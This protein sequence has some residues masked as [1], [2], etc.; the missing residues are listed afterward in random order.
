M[1][2]DPS[3][4]DVTDDEYA[5]VA[6]LLPMPEARGRPRLQPW[7]EL[8]DAVFYLVRTGCHWRHLPHEFPPWKTVYHYFRVWRLDGTWRRLHAALRETVRTAV[9][10]D[11]QPSGGIIDAQ[12][13]RTTSVGGPRGYDGGTKIS[14]RTRHLLVDTLGLV[15]RADVHTAEQ[16][17]RATVPRLLGGAGREFPRLNMVWLDQGY[18]GRGRE[19]IERELG[20]HVEVV[21]HP[22]TGRGGFKGIPDPTMP[23]GVR[24]VRVP[25]QK[26]RGL[27]GPLPRRWVVERSFAWFMHRRRCARDYERLPATDEMLISVAMTRLLLRRLARRAQK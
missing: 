1:A 24:I 15:L 7:R 17:E 5:R 6:P 2:R 26:G 8:L 13:V 27:R 18:T 19:W 10:R 14:G 16:Q 20:W 4:S 11:P 3:P 22:P 21:Q 23:Y 12:A 25:A 9:G